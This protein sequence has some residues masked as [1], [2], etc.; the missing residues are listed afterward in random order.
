MAFDERTVEFE[1]RFAGRRWDRAFCL[2]SLVSS[3]AGVT[4]G[5]S[6][7]LQRCLL[8][9]CPFLNETDLRS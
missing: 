9:G 2:L 7:W 3:C 1:R 5:C 4:L 6:G 8:A